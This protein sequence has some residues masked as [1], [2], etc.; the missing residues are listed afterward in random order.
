MFF[1]PS[2]LTEYL[3]VPDRLKTATLLPD[4]HTQPELTLRALQPV[5][6]HPAP[7]P[8]ELDVVQED[9]AV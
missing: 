2:G 3:D 4:G 5:P 9:H 6:A 8:G 7:S 1:S